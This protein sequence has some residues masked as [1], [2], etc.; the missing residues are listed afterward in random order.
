MPSSKV[1]KRK[2]TTA[3]AEALK[4][5]MKRPTRSSARVQTTLPAIVPPAATGMSSTIEN[6]DPRPVIKKEEEVTPKLEDA[7]P[8]LKLEE[9]HGETPEED[10]SFIDRD[11]YPL[12]MSNA[13]ADQ[14][15]NGGL[16]K[17]ID[18]LYSALEATASGR[19]TLKTPGKTVLHWFRQDFRLLDN[20]A[21]YLAAQK[22][23]SKP[24]TNI[25]AFYL[26][27]PEEYEA[28]V[29]SPARIDFI[30][31]T[32]K[33]LKD[34]LDK[35]DIPLYIETVDRR[36]NIAAKVIELAE[37]WDAKHIF[38][39]M[40]YEVDELRRDA[41]I[42]RRAAGKG[43]DF[44]VV[45]DSCIVPPGRLSTKVCLF[46]HAVLHPSIHPSIHLSFFS[47]YLT[48]QVLIIGWTYSLDRGTAVRS[49]YSVVQGLD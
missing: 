44:S 39:N 15:R 37:K 32:L 12:E 13:R 18:E 38:A 28:H 26:V 30:F 24:D 40:E 35:L 17:P 14:Y 6:T 11:F 49:I 5:P 33:V 34:D 20:T 36:K 22:A 29:R 4:P 23:R 48:E 41:R 31:R 2:L 46:T 10:K 3:A 8:R 19:K 42:V 1:P 16:P 47:Y 45:H 7:V 21:L 43:I 9:D 27:S 25:I